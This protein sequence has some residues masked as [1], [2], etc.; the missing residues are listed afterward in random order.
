MQLL[1]SSAYEHLHLKY[2]SSLAHRQKTMKALPRREMPHL[3]LKCRPQV[4]QSCRAHCTEELC[5]YLLD[6]GNR[7]NRNILP[8]IREK[9]IL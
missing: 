5:I 2:G 8:R 7:P 6:S 3:P 1:S 9:N 4:R